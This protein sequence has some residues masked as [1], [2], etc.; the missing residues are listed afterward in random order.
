[1][2]DWADHETIAASFKSASGLEVDPLDLL[3]TACRISHAKTYLFQILILLL[4]SEGIASLRP[5][6]SRML[7]PWLNLK[8]IFPVSMWL[9]FKPLSTFIPCLHST[10]SMARAPSHDNS[11]D[12]SDDNMPPQLLFV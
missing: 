3:K 4:H 8:L 6:A 2:P 1:M 12:I 9:H 11:R 10:G 7:E 5:L